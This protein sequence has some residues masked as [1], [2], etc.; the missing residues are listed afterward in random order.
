[1]DTVYRYSRARLDDDRIADL[2]L[3]CEYADLLAGAQQPAATRANFDDAADRPLRPLEGEA[4]QAFADHADEDDLGGD[5]RLADED[6]GDA[7][8]GQRQVGAELA[9]EQALDGAVEDPR[10]ADDRGQQREAV[11]VEELARPGRPLLDAQPRRGRRPEVRGDE[12]PDQ[13]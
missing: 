12:Q 11:A 4:F 7:G 2:D 5:E 3:R 1:H 8:D 13:R 9:F 10:A 6:P